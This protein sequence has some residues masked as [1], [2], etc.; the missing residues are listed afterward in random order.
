M[1]R[2]K[3]LPPLLFFPAAVAACVEVVKRIKQNIYIHTQ[4]NISEAVCKP[5]NWKKMFT[6]GE[7]KKKLSKNVL[8]FAVV[9]T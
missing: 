8:A 1:C 7:G 2:T 6:R 3:L 5:F 9:L 4:L